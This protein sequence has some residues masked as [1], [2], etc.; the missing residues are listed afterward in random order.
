[1]DAGLA[2]GMTVRVLDKDG[3][4]IAYYRE[5]QKGFPKELRNALREFR[6]KHPETHFIDVEFEQSD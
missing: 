6:E 2:E 3:D 5:A 1:M 4:K